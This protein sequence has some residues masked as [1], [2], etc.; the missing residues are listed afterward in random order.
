MLDLYGR[1]QW[2]RPNAAQP[3][4]AATLKLDTT[5]ARSALGWRPA[6][7]LAKAL[8]MVAEWHRRVDAGADARTIS[9]EQ[10]HIYRGLLAARLSQELE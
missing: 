4:E 10:I 9:L 3:H 1:E 8:E 6:L 5:K 2:D 7:N